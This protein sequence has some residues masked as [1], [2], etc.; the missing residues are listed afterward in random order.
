MQQLVLSEL[1][2]VHTLS[3]GFS[4]R[5]YTEKHGAELEPTEVY[6]PI[7]PKPSLS[8]SG[9]CQLKH[10]TDQSTFISTGGLSIHACL[11]EA[12]SEPNHLLWCAINKHHFNQK[13]TS[14]HNKDLGCFHMRLCE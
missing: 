1:K 8:L 9:R 3:Y 11:P 5:S 7:R 12:R 13:N 6:R 14:R 10:S 4:S 2:M